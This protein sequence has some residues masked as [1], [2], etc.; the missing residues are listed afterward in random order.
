MPA[1]LLIL[2]GGTIRV[3]FATIYSGMGTKITAVEKG[4]EIG[5]GVD[6][7]ISAFLLAGCRKRG[8]KFHLNA[9]TG[10]IAFKEW[11]K[12]FNNDTALTSAVLDRILHHCE[13]VTIDGKSCRLQEHAKGE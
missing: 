3:K 6:Q 1:K 10:N 8:M 11:G 13:V 4:A 12:I 2:G 9:A 5:G 7:R